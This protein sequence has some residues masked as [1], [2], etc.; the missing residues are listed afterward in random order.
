MAV[1]QFVLAAVLWVRPCIAIFH[2]SR[3][4]KSF[5]AL[6]ASELSGGSAVPLDFYMRDRLACVHVKPLLSP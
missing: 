6:R 3:P 5:F 1:G 2:P 4:D